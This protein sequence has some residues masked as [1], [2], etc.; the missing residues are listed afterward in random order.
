VNGRYGAK[1]KAVR[2]RHRLAEASASVAYA[3]LDL[4]HLKKQRAAQGHQEHTRLHGDNG[5]R[6]PRG[7]AGAANGDER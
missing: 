4:S 7:A 3:A 5:H 1:D 2:F 6:T